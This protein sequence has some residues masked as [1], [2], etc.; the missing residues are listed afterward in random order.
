MPS[1][2]DQL[3]VVL[4]EPQKPINIAG[5]VRAMKNM[6]VRDLRLVR[7]CAYEE[8]YIEVIAHDTRD[9]VA[10][11]R[12]HSTLDD[13]LADCVRVA[14]F[15]GKRRATEAAPPVQRCAWARCSSASVVVV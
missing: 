2:L 5:T 8:N 1:V 14:A 7:P 6:G 10:G 15:T 9:L 4:Y 13:A 3:R 12:H 11:I